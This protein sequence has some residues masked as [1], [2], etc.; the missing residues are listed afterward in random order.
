MRSG[1]PP[2]LGQV[3]AGSRPAVAHLGIETRPRGHEEPLGLGNVG[4][5]DLHALVVGQR[6]GDELVEHR[7][8]ELLPP[9]GVGGL[10]GHVLRL[11]AE[12]LG[13]IDDRALVIG[14]HGA[15]GYRQGN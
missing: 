12:G 6:V 14:P 11:E 1:N 8:V 5:G 2:I 7:I 9:F 13:E 15:A 10:L 4:G 3:L